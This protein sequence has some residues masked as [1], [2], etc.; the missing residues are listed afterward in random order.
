MSLD[1]KGMVQTATMDNLEC[2]LCGKCVD[3]CPREVISYTAKPP[4]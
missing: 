4:S 2:V 3:K 1:V